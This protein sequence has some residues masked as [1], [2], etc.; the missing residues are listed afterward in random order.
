M[1][2]AKMALG[3]LLNESEEDEG[4]Q[5]LMRCPPR[6]A[7]RWGGGSVEIQIKFESSARCW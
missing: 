3:F 2:S 5:T 6:A 7:W 4:R 1:G